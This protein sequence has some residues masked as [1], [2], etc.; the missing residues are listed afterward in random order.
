WELANLIAL[1]CNTTTEIAINAVPL[2]AL[3][4]PGSV[5]GNVSQGLNFG[6]INVIGDP[7]P[8]VDVSLEQNPGGIMVNQTQTDSN[9]DY[10]F[11]NIPLGDYRVGVSIPGTPQNSYYDVSLNTE[12]PTIDNL[13]YLV[14]KD[15][16]YILSIKFN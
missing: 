7:I 16:I 10:S 3:S 13:M 1:A 6:K 11:S 2:P 12:K 15:E 4:G 14:D 9:G 8:G 5:S